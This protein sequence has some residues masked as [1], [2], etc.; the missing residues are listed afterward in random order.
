MPE[1][2]RISASQFK[3]YDLCKRK[4][5][6]TRFQGL[7]RTS[8]PALELG[9]AVHGAVEAW[10]TDGLT[11]DTRT[12]DGK[13][14]FNVKSLLPPPNTPHVHS[15]QKVWLTDIDPP[16]LGYIDVLD[17]RKD[18]PVVIDV[19]T[20]SDWKWAKT[21]EQLAVDRQMIPYAVHAL[22]VSAA[23]EVTVAHAAVIK[24]GRLES[25][26]TE[27]TLPAE[28][29]LEV[30]DDLKA[31]AGRMKETAKAETY[32]AVEPDWTACGAYG[33]C[34]YID[35]CQA[36]ENTTP[37]GGAPRYGAQRAGA[38]QA[39]ESVN[40]YDRIHTVKPTIKENPVTK[41]QEL[42]ARK[43]ASASIN[44]PDN[45]AAEPVTPRPTP[46]EA[47]T[48]AQAEAEQAEPF[49]QPEVE[50]TAPVKPQAKG[51]NGT[52]PEQYGEAASAVLRAMRS[53]KKKALSPTQFKAIVGDAL[54]LL[55]VNKKHLPLVCDHSEGTLVFVEGGGCRRAVADVIE[56]K[57]EEAIRTSTT[58]AERIEKVAAA[59]PAMADDESRKAAA[60]AAASP[61]AELKRQAKATNKRADDKVA[62]ATRQRTEREGF[63]LLVDCLPQKGAMKGLTFE[64]LIAPI[65][66]KVSKGNGVSDPLVMDYGK[67]KDLVAALLRVEPIEAEVVMVNS[68]SAYWAA[69]STCLVQRAGTVIRGTR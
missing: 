14:A 39:T 23:P 27:V 28:R 2:K 53:E 4:H 46:A 59:S 13:L 55:R 21:S 44:P 9:T 16:L 37:W 61:N 51:P 18:T 34:P 26:W 38:A 3:E 5:W 52:T 25:R 11:P 22:A 6:I 64:T 1:L 45:G 66:E 7:P 35:I 24:R 54:G 68:Q 32:D 62:D 19:K 30:W 58:A 57:I 12:P 29:V 60:E 69:C 50:V 10:L 15:E 43:R 67:G 42:L 31:L 17:L 33:G 65:I 40:P 49:P 41:L 36:T 8:S 48:I 56:G 63:T 20:V 47:A